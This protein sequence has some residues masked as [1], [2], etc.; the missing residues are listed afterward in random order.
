MLER[1]AEVIERE[2]L[3]HNPTIVF[4]PL[5]ASLSELYKKGYAIRAICYKVGTK[6]PWYEKIHLVKGREKWLLGRVPRSWFLENQRGTSSSLASFVKD[7]VQV[8]HKSSFETY[9]PLEALGMLYPKRS[10]KKVSMIGNMT[11]KEFV[12]EELMTQIRV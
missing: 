9:A 1:E 4:G 6:S 8:I 7:G 10:Q 2:V 3:D 12:R 11:I 5:S